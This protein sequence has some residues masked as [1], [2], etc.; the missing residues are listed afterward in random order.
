MW[1]RSG[2]PF[3][4]TALIHRVEALPQMWQAK[5]TVAPVAFAQLTHWVEVSCWG[6]QGQQIR[7]ATFPAQ[8]AAH[9]DGVL[10]R[11]K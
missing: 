10:L 2:A 1:L 5:N 8:Y 6:R 9:K 11:E 3:L 4:H 7:E